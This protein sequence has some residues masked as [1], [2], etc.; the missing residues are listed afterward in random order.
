MLSS[1]RTTVPT[2]QAADAA[3]LRLFYEVTGGAT[4]FNRS[5][6]DSDPVSCVAA[7]VTCGYGGAVVGLS[8]SLNPNPYATAWPTYNLSGT[9]P[10][11]LGR[12]MELRVL[13]LDG[14]RV[15]A[16]QGFLGPLGS[17]TGGVPTEVGSLTA[18]N[19]LS[20]I[21]N[22]L[23]G[24]LPT[25]LGRLTALN[26]RFRVEVNHLSGTIPSQIGRWTS[27]GNVNPR[28]PFYYYKG[29]MT[30]RQTR[31]RAPSRPKSAGSRRCGTHG[32]IRTF[33]RARCR[34]KS[35]TAQT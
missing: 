19:E 21:N 33:S 24:T 25:Q 4:W 15:D 1:N 28:H 29:F 35:A 14:G 10:T 31:S 13:N 16:G 11:Q 22:R 18:L 23:S 5:G 30:F 32:L 3:V 2:M 17:L 12:L 8:F 34:P 6:W 26:G 20:L 7:G 27:M 9:L